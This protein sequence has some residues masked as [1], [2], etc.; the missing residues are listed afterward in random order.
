MY[1]LFRAKSKKNGNWVYGG[2]V[3]KSLYPSD[4]FISE[5]YKVSLSDHTPCEI[6]CIDI[7]TLCINT[8]IVDTV[9][10]PIFAGDIIRTYYKRKYRLTC[11]SLCLSKNHR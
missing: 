10:N 2:H 8:G 1:D 11:K 9:I 6:C 4:Y 7:Q 3:L 5:D